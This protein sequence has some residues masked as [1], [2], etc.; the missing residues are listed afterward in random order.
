LKSFTA[1]NPNTNAL[2]SSATPRE[3]LQP[4]AGPV[5]FDISNPGIGLGGFLTQVRRRDSTGPGEKLEGKLWLPEAERVITQ[6][7]QAQ[8]IA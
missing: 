3:Y 7:P 8:T 6:Q 5:P 4:Y 1:W 2:Y